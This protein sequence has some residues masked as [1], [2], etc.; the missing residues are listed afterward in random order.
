MENVENV[1]VRVVVEQVIACQYL[2]VVPLF[3]CLNI[4]L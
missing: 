1:T 2:K 3:K 4:Q